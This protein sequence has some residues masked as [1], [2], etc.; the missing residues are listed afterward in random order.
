MDELK[1][2]P[3]LIS[4]SLENTIF[5]R[6]QQ[7]EQ[8]R[9]LIQISKMVE[10]REM[11]KIKYLKLVLESYLSHNSVADDVPGL[12][13]VFPRKLTSHMNQFFV[14]LEEFS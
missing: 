6:I 7:K 5:Q 1:G 9:D 11:V 2:F 13:E 10:D 12:R 4:P 3:L 8:K 14:K